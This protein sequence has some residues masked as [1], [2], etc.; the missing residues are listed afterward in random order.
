MNE[1]DVSTQTKRKQ[2]ETKEDFERKS[3]GVQREE[4]SNEQERTGTKERPEKNKKSIEKRKKDFQRKSAGVQR[5]R[6]DFKRMRGVERTRQDLNE[7]EVSSN[8]RRA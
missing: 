1:R 5:K 2:R 4:E 3:A 8:E 7:R 6:E